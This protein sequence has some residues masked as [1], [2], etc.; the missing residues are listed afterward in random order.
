MME[1]QQA[2]QWAQDVYK[3]NYQPDWSTEFC[4]WFQFAL[5]DYALAGF[6]KG[7]HLMGFGQWNKENG[8]EYKGK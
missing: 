7:D 5:K 3:Q 8:T 6:P 1:T 2:T 4:L